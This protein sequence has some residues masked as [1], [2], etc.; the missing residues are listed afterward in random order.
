MDGDV[1]FKIAIPL[2][3]GRSDYREVKGKLFESLIGRFLAFQSYTVKERIRDAG[4][5][6]DLKCVSKLSGDT[7]IV[8]CKARSETVQTDAVNKIHADVAVESANCGW[9]FS[10]S[11]IGKEAQAR[12][13]KLNERAGKPQYRF[14]PPHELVQ[15]IVQAQGFRL[16]S[17][18]TESRT[19]EVFLCLFEGREIWA[20]PVWTP[21]RELNGLL[22]WG[23]NDASPIRPKDLPDLGNTDFPYPEAMWL[24]RKG[25]DG[26]QSRDIQPIV[27][28]IPGEEWSDYR[29]PVPPILSGAKG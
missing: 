13:E 20:V 28:V 2:D 18:P 19:T 9:I 5:E 27:E 1:K 29:S 11:D 26:P 22:A 17:L 21:G 8:E 23:A 14:F 7:A 4:T 12:L 6:I 3:K 16:P 10:I 15:L 25:V 24:D